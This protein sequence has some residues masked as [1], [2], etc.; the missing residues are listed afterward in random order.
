MAYLKLATDVLKGASNN[1]ALS[2]DTLQEKARYDHDPLKIEE[3]LKSLGAASV[4]NRDAA[5]LNLYADVGDNSG[6]ILDPDLDSY[7]LMSIALDL[8]PKLTLLQAQLAASSGDATQRQF[9]IAQLKDTE[10]RISQA[11]Q[12]AIKATP[13]LTKNLNDEWRNSNRQLISAAQQTTIPASI[14][15]SAIDDALHLN[16][17]SLSVLDDLLVKRIDGQKAT[18]DIYLMITAAG[19]LLAAYFIY[20]FYTSETRGIG[21]LTKRMRNLAEGNLSADYG[22]RGADEIGELINTYE[23]SRNQLFKLVE[24]IHEVADTVN[25]AGS[26]I[27]SANVDLSQRTSQQSIII[28]NT[29]NQVEQV[30]NKVVSNLESAT[31]A[32]L[33]SREA[34]TAAEKGQQIMDCVVK[35]INAMKG[36]SA[37]IGA[38]IGVINEIAFQTNLLALN[39]AVEAARAGEQGRGFAVVAGEVR[40]LAQ[41]CATAANEISQLIKSSAVEVDQGVAQVAIAGTSMR[42]ILNSVRTVSQIMSEMVDAGKS[43]SHAIGGIKSAFGRIENDAQQNAAMVEQTA[44][45]A[46]LLRE[47]VTRLLTSISQFN[48]DT[49][50]ISSDVSPDEQTVDLTENQRDFRSAA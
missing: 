25:T 35:T 34:Y 24:Q 12:R 37:K 22:A 45:A 9:V 27:A 33:I 2:A 20:G 32:N 1:V 8:S 39:A 41:R 7:Y 43:Q 6:L 14:V 42:E 18:R 50:E 28:G 11:M 10:Y 21:A 19:L 5:L 29:A 26:E 30:I 48:V 46:E 36:S 40:N 23:H 4:D 49:N 15:R 31:N 3:D 17:S 44:S 38:I 47:Q 16:K 13:D